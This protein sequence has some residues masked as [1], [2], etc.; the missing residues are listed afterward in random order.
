MKIGL[1][2]RGYSETGGAEAYLRRFAAGIVASGHQCALFTSRKWPREE[3]PHEIFRVPGEDSPRAFARSLV[4]LGAQE[5]CDLLFSLE[6]VQTC[7]C[8]RAG[9]GV[10]R[11]WL[12]RREQAEPGFRAWLRRWNPKH[13]EILALEAEL[14]SKGGARG[15]IANSHMVKAEIAQ[16]Y[17]QYPAERIHVVH[18]GVPR[19]EVSQASYAARVQTRRELNIADDEYVVLFAGSG[20]ERKG[21]AHAIEAMNAAALPR[22]VLLVAG[23]GDKSAMPKSRH[24]MFLG[25]VKDM[26]RH[27]AAA[28]AF[29]LPTLY[30]P[31]SNACLEALA[32][33]L[34][35]I[36][37]SNNGFSEIIEPGVEGDVIAD[38][39]NVLALAQAISGWND[40]ARR[41]AVREQLVA[42][43]A[44]YSIE[45]NIRQ[46]LAIFRAL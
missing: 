6:R 19:S 15:V 24:T 27:F 26:P 32:A 39:A 12:A 1:I 4:K 23:S 3:W 46:T 30:D 11:A 14:F 37:T 21:L 5:R 45:E 16:H 13:R 43:G 8:Y 33:G 34:P 18:N 17:P 7:D 9:D 29:L 10:H 2:R 41:A 42:K 20:W 40:P 28:D 36:T 35:V 22:A 31:F 44:R 25:P 38:P